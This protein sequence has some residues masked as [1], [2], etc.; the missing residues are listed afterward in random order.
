M[1]GYNYW[2]LYLQLSMNTIIWK[3]YHRLLLQSSAF[4][5][6]TTLYE[7]NN[8]ET[9]WKHVRKKNAAGG[10]DGV[11][12]EDLS[13]KIEKT[14]QTLAKELETQKYIPTP[15]A[16]AK[17]PKFNDKNEWRKL[18]LPAVRDKIVQQAFV[19]VTEPFINPAFLDCSYAYRVGKGSVRA[20]KRVEHILITNDIRWIATI[21]IDDFFDC[22]DHEI[23]IDELKILIKSPPMINLVNLWLQA[24]IINAKGDWDAPDEGIAQGSIISPIFSNV[25]LNKLD[26]YAV[27]NK[28]HYIRYSDN[29]IILAD[30]KE[31]IYA[32]YK[33]IK[34][35]IGIQLKLRLNDNPYPFKDI[36]QGFAFLGIFFKG[37]VRFKNNENYKGCE[38]R[39]SKQ[40]ETKIFRKINWLTD[41]NYQYN[42]DKTIRQINESVKGTK[43]YYSFIQPVEQFQTFDKHLQK[44]I[45]FLFT[46]FLSRKIIQSQNEAVAILQRLEFY[47]YKSEQERKKIITDLMSEIH[48]F[49][50]KKPEKIKDTEE[51]KTEQK[52]KNSPEKVQSAQ[53]ID[54]HIIN[55][56]R[57]S[58]EAVLE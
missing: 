11:S 26:H 35:F 20:I 43:R 28:F 32:V 27:T 1:I 57:R 33:Q 44:R 30:T 25:Y 10:I 17:I 29:F 24:G 6:F 56:T 5:L 53:A 55:F 16:Q 58:E 3:Q 4:A 37:S 2:I 12:P 46:H 41:K 23:L 49:I 47:I 21:D 39:I 31:Q 45:K 14:L 36:D 22:L 34:S 9:A 42:A 13:A 15:Y 7:H 48:S 40:K 52:L 19:Q 50:E 18:S 38:R 8:L 51:T 54:C